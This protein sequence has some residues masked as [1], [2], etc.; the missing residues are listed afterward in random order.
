MG[1]PLAQAQIFTSMHVFGSTDGANP[2]GALVQGADGTF[3]GTTSH[4][5]ANGPPGG[6]VFRIAADGTLTTLHHFCSDPLCPDGFLSSAGLALSANGYF[7]GTTAAG[8]TGSFGTVFK[9]TPGGTLTTLYSFCSQANCTDGYSPNAGLVPDARGNLYGTTLYGGTPDNGTVF[10]ITP[11]GTLTT[12]YS[13]CSQANCSDGAG[14]YAGLVLATD[15][16]FY[17]TTYY[18]GVAGGGTVF[19]IT[20][21]GTLTTLHSFAGVDGLN[22]AGA[23]AEGAHGALYGTTYQGGTYG[24]VTVFRVTPPGALTMLYSFGSQSAGADGS[25]PYAGPVLATD[26]NFYGTTVYG[27]GSENGTIF[28]ITPSGM[29][30]TLYSFCP[31]PLTGCTD[32]AEPYAG[33]VEGTSGIFYGTTSTGAEF[34]TVF[35]LSVGLGPFVKTIPCSGK[36]GEVVKILGT[37]LDGATTVSFGGMPAVFN[38]ISSSEITTTVPAG[39]T[40]GTVQVTTSS[41]TFL[42]N[43]AF[44]VP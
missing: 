41:G 3:Y 20:P 35:S 19:K 34:G 18:G 44:Q 12:L 43:A 32:G 25:H 22:P 14:A 16:N 28:Q 17:G 27:G 4:G 37:G 24:I 40:S 8:G 7:Y 2:Y 42:S 10:K 36:I 23:L 6:T 9:M 33:L 39:A 29:L 1:I 5:E 31:S 13:F 38:V 21:S 15:G 11:S 30:T 26:G